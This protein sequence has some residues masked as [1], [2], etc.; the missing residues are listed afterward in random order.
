M[1]AAPSRRNILGWVM[2][3]REQYSREG[4]VSGAKSCLSLSVSRLFIIL[5]VVGSDEF[6]LMVTLLR[7][8]RQT[9]IQSI[10]VLAR[11]Q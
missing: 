7:D 4:A 8:F 9:S 2:I 11:I 10:Q 1:S 6:L 3:G 5:C